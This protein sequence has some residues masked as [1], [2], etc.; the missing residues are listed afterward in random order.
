MITANGIMQGNKGE[1]NMKRCLAILLSLALLLPL[2][3][4]AAT[5]AEVEA[6]ALPKPMP[7]PVELTPTYTEPFPGKIAIITNSD[8]YGAEEYLSAKEVI[9]KY[10]EDKVIHKAWPV[11]YFEEGDRMIMMLRQIAADPEVKALIINQMIP[12]SLIAVDELLKIRNDMFLVAIQPIEDLSDIAARFNLILNVDGVMMGDAMPIQARKLGA[13]TFVHLS[14]PRHMSYSIISARFEMLKE[15]CEEIGIEFVSHTVPD[16]TGDIGIHGAQQFML[17]EI[18]KLVAK[19]GQN[20]A[21]FCTNCILQ[22]PLIKAVV[23]AG[24]IYLQPCCPS[25][26]HGFPSALGLVDEGDNVFVGADS[27]DAI[28]YIV[29]KTTE[30]LAEKNMLGRLSTWP[31][32]ISILNVAASAEYA[33]KWINGEASKEGIDYALL[34][35]CMADYAGVKC[36]VRTLGTHEADVDVADGEYPNWVF[37]MEDYYTYGKAEDNTLTPVQNTVGNYYGLKAGATA[38]STISY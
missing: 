27:L 38:K 17:E 25:P 10:G 32:P 8:M 1:I 16:Y 11:R 4:C 26:F 2:A 31:I 18:P 5:L 37:V 15:N 36:S 7:T 29:S 14:F 6:P 12:D 19:Y 20:T 34:E 24:A 30:K 9:A 23:D 13:K 33:I 22:A 21:F 35:Q 3:A 28:S